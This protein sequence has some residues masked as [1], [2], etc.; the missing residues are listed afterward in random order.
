L[1]EYFDVLPFLRPYRKATLHA[2]D[3][4]AV[5]NSAGQ[6]RAGQAAGKNMN[7]H[8][9]L[10]AQLE[11]LLDWQDAHVSFDTAVDGLPPDLRGRQPE[12]LPYSPWQLVEHIRRCQWDILDFCR[13]SSYK[14]PRFEEYWPP[15][16]VPPS[17]KAWDESVASI[18]RDRQALQRLARDASVDL[19]ARIPHGDGQT[20]LRELVLVADH[21]A[22]H[23]G[24]LV[25]VRRLLGAWQGIARLT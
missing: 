22:Y 16:A 7:Q 10:R 23:V 1:N 11:K 3:R 5:R 12:G 25:A 14:E 24:Q 15:S 2:L 17:S 19:A 20:Y 13:N 6:E 4:L 18:R 21:T 8:D 9:A